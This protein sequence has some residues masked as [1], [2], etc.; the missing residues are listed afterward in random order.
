MNPGRKVSCRCL[1]WGHWKSL[2]IS[3]RMGAAGYPRAL[4][5][6]ASAAA[7]SVTQTRVTERSFMVDPNSSG[8]HFVEVAFEQVVIHPIRPGR[9]L[10]AAGDDH[11]RRLVDVRDR[12]GV[13]IE[14]HFGKD[15]GILGE[16]LH[17]LL[18]GGG[19]DGGH[20]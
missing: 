13:H 7:A 5:L 9:L 15:R 2:Y 3:T 6:S 1:Q 14:L 11:G 8:E 19:E 17:L 10:H 18:V 4:P 16:R 20:S 12:A